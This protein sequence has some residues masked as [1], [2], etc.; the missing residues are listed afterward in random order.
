MTGAE[1]AHGQHTLPTDFDDLN[2]LYGIQYEMPCTLD[3]LYR[4][5]ARPHLRYAAAILGDKSAAKAVVRQLYNHL[6]MDW[7]GIL[8]KGGS[9][10]R[11]AWRTLKRLVDDRAR[12]NLAGGTLTAAL[13][14]C[15][16]INA[17]RSAVE[18]TLS[19]MR[20]QMADLESPLGLYT[21]I[22][23]LPE[24]QFDVIVLHYALG[25]PSQRV[26]EIMG[27]HPGT[28]RA[29]RRLAR[30]RIAVNLGIDLGDD[31]DKE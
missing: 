7:A 10:E 11:Y 17:V 22:A 16:R 8:M 30:E 3:A 1:D 4:R 15:D 24:R 20:S 29:H 23:A 31:E 19:A 21:A 13:A 6:A 25:Y 27:I 14:A 28:V 5:S 26:A 2:G 9:V 12:E 18:A